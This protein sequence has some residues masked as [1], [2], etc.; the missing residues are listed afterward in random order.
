[1][2]DIENSLSLYGTQLEI[3]DLTKGKSHLPKE[4]F[5]KTRQLASVRIHVE[6]L[7]GLTRQKYTVLQ[8]LDVAPTEKKMKKLV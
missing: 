6:R 3:Q 4:D 7:I 5:E 1:M 8:D 2:F